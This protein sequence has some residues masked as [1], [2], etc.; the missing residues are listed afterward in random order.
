MVQKYKEGIKCDNFSKFSKNY[1]VIK[2]ISPNLK[3]KVNKETNNI[4]TN[5][6]NENNQNVM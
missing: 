4:A 1:F 5:S 2:S 6:I 3:N